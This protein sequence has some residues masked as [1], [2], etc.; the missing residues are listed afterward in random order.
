MRAESYSFIW[1]PWVLMNN[2]PDMGRP[3]AEKAAQCTRARASI[4]G[5]QGGRTGKL[6]ADSRNFRRVA[7]VAAQP[8]E[9]IRLHL[10]PSIRLLLVVGLAPLAVNAG[11]VRVFKDKRGVINIVS[12]N[13]RLPGTGERYYKRV[14]SKG[15]VHFTSKPPMSGGYSVVY[16]DACPA[17]D[18]HS[19]VNWNSTRLN[20]TAYAEEIS[21][22]AAANG[23]DAALVRALIHAES[24]F[25]P[26]ARSHKGAQGLMQLMPATAGMYGVSNAYDGAQNIRAGVQHL[27]MLLKNYDGDVKLAAAAYNA[28]EGAVKKYGGVP[29]YAETRVYVDRVE[30]LMKRY[31]QAQQTASLGASS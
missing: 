8:R 28:G 23:V 20:T 30:I 1:Q 21:A 22:A 15:T 26:N 9:S 11:D 3:R 18:V 24:A 6:R 16:V 2:L 5:C 13:S 14:D 12:T 19:T 10:H 27:A 7:A 31:Q 17:C 29:P 4:V 25:N